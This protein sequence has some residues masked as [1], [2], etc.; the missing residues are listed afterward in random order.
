MAEEL[1]R[2]PIHRRDFYSLNMGNA[3]SGYHSNP[4]HVKDWF[5]TILPEGEPTVL[6]CPSHSVHT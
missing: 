3:K 4:R 6:V 1:N 5:G 2:A